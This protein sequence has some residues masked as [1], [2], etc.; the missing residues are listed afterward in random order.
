MRS[1][2][3]LQVTGFDL[4]ICLALSVVNSLQKVSPT[5]NHNTL[6][7]NTD[8]DTQLH[9]QG[10][11]RVVGGGRR[12]TKRSEKPVLTIFS[13]RDISWSTLQFLLYVAGYIRKRPVF[14]WLRGIFSR[15]RQTELSPLAAHRERRERNR[16]GLSSFPLGGLN[17][18]VRGSSMRGSGACACLPLR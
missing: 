15:G 11:C 10:S 3:Y 1:T 16:L 2:L 4:Y 7:I 9:V 5:L 12:L 13:M 14:T 8:T 6:C 18:K 17:G